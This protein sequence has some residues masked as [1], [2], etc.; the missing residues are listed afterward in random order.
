MAAVHRFNGNQM[1][2]SKKSKFAALCAVI[3]LSSLTMLELLWRFPIPTCIA[4]V[5]LLGCLLHCART[6]RLLELALGPMDNSDV[7]NGQH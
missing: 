4:S 2:V 5:V 7:T 3:A 1:T 6:A